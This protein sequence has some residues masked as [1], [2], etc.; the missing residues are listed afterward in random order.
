ML[1]DQSAP[2]AGKGLMVIE[3]RIVLHLPRKWEKACCWKRYVAGRKML[4]E[5]CDTLTGVATGQ[6]RTPAH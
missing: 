4:A 2:S 3:G 5:K 1:R 6:Q